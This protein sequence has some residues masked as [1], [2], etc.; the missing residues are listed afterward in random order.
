MS[1][2][3]T[4]DDGKEEF[5]IAIEAE[6]APPKSEMVRVARRFPQIKHIRFEALK[7]FPRTEAGMQKIKQS[8]VRKI[9]VG[10]S[11]TFQ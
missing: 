4:E 7:R 1:L 6:S 5:V 9:L 10:R 2:F 3:R 11:D 8:K